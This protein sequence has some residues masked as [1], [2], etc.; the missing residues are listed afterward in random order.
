[1]QIIRRIENLRGLLKKIR[2]KNQTVGFVATMGALHTGHL[3]LIR[4]AHLDSDLV[5]VSIF[6]NPIQFGPQEDFKKYPRNLSQDASL[7]RRAE[8]DILFYPDMKE[9]Y[10]HDHK[11]Y[12]E[13]CDLSDCL[14]GEFRPGHFKGVATVVAKL[15]NIVQPDIAYFGQKDAQ[16]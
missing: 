16:P 2:L 3:S 1:M 9:M 15:F 14:C 10:P 11:T 5:V 4:K 6:V 12:V 7:C 8:V 13:V